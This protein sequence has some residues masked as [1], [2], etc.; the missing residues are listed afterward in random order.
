[1]LLFVFVTYL[2]T[3]SCGML[4]LGI[5]QLPVS[6]PVTVS[7]TPLPRGTLWSSPVCD[8]LTMWPTVGKMPRFLRQRR[9]PLRHI[10]LVHQL[11]W[12]KRRNELISRSFSLSYKCRHETAPSY[13]AD[14]R[15]QPPD[16]EARCLLRHRRWL[17]AVRVCQP[18]VRPNFSGRHGSCLEWSAAA[19]HICTITTCFHHHHRHF[20]EASGTVTHNAVYKSYIS[21]SLRQRETAHS[22]I[23]YSPYS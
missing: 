13:L 15:S 2:F 6:K 19:R 16:F 11:R 18:S 7:V 1:M 14:E 22:T 5:L 3:Y 10:P 21:R 23:A 8:V 9:R 17:S 20:I 12:L 4:L